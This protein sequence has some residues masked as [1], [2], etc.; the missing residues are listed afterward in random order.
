MEKNIDQTYNQKFTI[1][2]IRIGRIS[3]FIATLAC[4]VPSIYLAIRYGARP[5]IG[6]ILAGWGLTAAV[7]APFYFIEPISYFPVLGIAGTYM[8]FLAGEIGNMRLP[9][10][11][12]AQSVLKV[13]EGTKKSELVG[14]LAIAGSVVTSVIAGTLSVFVGSFILN[15]LPASVLRAFDFVL[16]AVFGSMFAIKAPKFG[17]YALALVLILKIFTPLPVFAILPL[18]VFSTIAF[19]IFE[20]KKKN[21]KGAEK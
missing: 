18:T 11:A 14:T 15:V 16:P 6:A 9:C 7:Y 8:S 3:M 10:A 12:V 2:V 17:V 19:G 21:S 4:F 20:H 13:E 1:P 5:P